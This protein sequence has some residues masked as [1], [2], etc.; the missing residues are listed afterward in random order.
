MSCGTQSY[1][2]LLALKQVGSGLRQGSLHVKK[3]P[4]DSSFHSIFVNMFTY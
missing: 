1:A 3:N 4:A 2:P